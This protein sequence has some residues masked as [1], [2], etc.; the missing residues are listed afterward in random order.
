MSSFGGAYQG[1]DVL[2]TG[3]TGF[4]GSWLALWL[5]QLGARTTGL[6]LDPATDPALC[7]LADACSGLTDHRGDI[8]DATLLETLIGD[9]KPKIILH[10]AAQA[11]VRESYETPLDTLNT[12]VMGTANLLEAV[13]RSGHPCSVVIVTS[14]KCYENVNWDYGYR[15]TDPMGG[16]DPYSMSKGAT[17]LVVSSWRRSFF[18]PS[19]PIRVASA[20]AGNVIGGGD[21]ARDRIMTDCISALCAGTPIGVRNPVATRPWQHVLEPLSGYLELGARM[22]EPDGGR[23]ATGWNFGP[24]VQS[25]CNVQRLV[26]G[27]ISAWGSGSWEDLSDPS[28]VHEAKLLSLTWEK[29]FHHL[30]WEPTWSLDQCLTATADWYRGWHEQPGSAR[31]NCLTQIDAYESRAR[32]LGLAW[33]AGH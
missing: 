21:W 24:A 13:R 27:M 10:L 6:A 19:G 22:L 28:A 26:E 4:K 25:V 14:D 8:R 18:D 12:N 1:T 33:A 7:T 11:I 3:H 31:T 29:A 30:S 23:F 20:R 5:E 9:T 16:S 17:E 15:E 32:E 2:L